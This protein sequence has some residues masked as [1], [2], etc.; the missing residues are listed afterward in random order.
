MTQDQLSMIFEYIH[1]ESALTS[2]RSCGMPF[3]AEMDKRGELHIKLLAS[4]AVEKL[5]SISNRSKDSPAPHDGVNKLS[6]L[7]V[8]MLMFAYHSGHNMQKFPGIQCRAQQQAYNWFMINDYFQATT[9][10]SSIK[11]TTKGK[12]LVEKILNTTVTVD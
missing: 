4:I 10:M 7:M 9:L 1:N 6:P 5:P 11:L 12:A 8:D 2:L 3:Q